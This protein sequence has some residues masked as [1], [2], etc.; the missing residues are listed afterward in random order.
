MNNAD[1]PTFIRLPGFYWVKFKGNHEIAKW[2]DNNAWYFCG[3]GR[4]YADIQMDEINES[5]IKPLQ[6]LETTKPKL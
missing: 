2:M 3:D 5:R 6:Q 4:A 1:Q